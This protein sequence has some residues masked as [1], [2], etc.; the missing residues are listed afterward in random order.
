MAGLVID[1]KRMEK[2]IDALKSVH[3]K[4]GIFDVNWTRIA[5]LDMTQPSVRCPSNLTE[6]SN[7]FTG[8]RAC[9]KSSDPGC[10]SVFSHLRESIH[11]CVDR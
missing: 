5:Y 4:C 8:Q 6:H 3:T 7:N 1:L 9:G 2:E 11:K 10:L